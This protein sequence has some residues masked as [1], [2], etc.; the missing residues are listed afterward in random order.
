MKTEW[1]KS[2]IQKAGQAIYE[3]DPTLEPF[4]DPPEAEKTGYYLQAQ[5]SLK[6]FLESLER[7]VNE[8]Y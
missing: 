2:V 5:A 1:S 7:I 6:S 3:A 4:N 8:S